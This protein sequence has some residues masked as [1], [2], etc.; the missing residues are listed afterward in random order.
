MDN[1][2]EAKPHRR[3]CSFASCGKQKNA[4]VP[5]RPAPSLPRESSAHRGLRA[6]DCPYSPKRTLGPLVPHCIYT[7]SF[8]VVVTGEPE[9]PCLLCVPVAKSLPRRSQRSFVQPGPLSENEEATGCLFDTRRLSCRTK[10]TQP[11]SAYKL[12][13]RA[14]C[15]FRWGMQ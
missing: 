4:P 14:Q 12:S 6:E 7:R 5:A 11:E 2:L 1:L 8:T 10:A 15:R 13:C 9:A 3:S